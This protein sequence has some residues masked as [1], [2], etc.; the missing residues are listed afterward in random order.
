[1]LEV[2]LKSGKQKLWYTVEILKLIYNYL[3]AIFSDYMILIKQNS[4]Y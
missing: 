4:S 3:Q 2:S 1:M